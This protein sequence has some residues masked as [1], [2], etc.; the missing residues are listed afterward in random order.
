MLDRNI[1]KSAAVFCGLAFIFWAD[2][3]SEDW[4]QKSVEVAGGGNFEFEFPTSWGKKPA[5]DTADGITSVRF[6][7]YGPRKKPFFLV[8][9]ETV[10]TVEPVTSEATNKLAELD[11]ENFKKIAA[12]T[13]IPIN[14]IKGPEVIGHYFSITDRTPKLG[15]FDYVTVAILGSDRLI[16]KIYFYSSD[17]APDF[18]ADAM[19]L[20]R[21][22]RYT[23]PP[24]EPDGDTKKK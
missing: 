23:A 14:D 2:A 7:P 18:G 17:G 13:D 21:S 3:R 16:I 1:C 22:I 10:S 5:L 20:M 24:P 4:M 19:Q 6:G 9:I 12:E 15:E 8:H 11:V